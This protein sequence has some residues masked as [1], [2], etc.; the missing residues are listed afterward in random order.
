LARKS[1]LLAGFSA[2]GFDE[3]RNLTQLTPTP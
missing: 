1:P 2:R 3:R